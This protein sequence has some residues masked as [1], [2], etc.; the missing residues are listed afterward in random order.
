[1]LET[2]IEEKGV[3]LDN[4]QTEVEKLLSLL[5]HR[6]PGLMSWNMFLLERFRN[7]HKITSQALGK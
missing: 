3:D 6:E 4:L 1:M 2:I 7:L 5:K